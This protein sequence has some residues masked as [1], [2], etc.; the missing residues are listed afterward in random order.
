M[1]AGFLHFCTV[2][3][4]KE[5][6]W[7]WYDKASIVGNTIF[8]TITI[9]TN[10][11]LEEI[12]YLGSYTFGLVSGPLV[13]PAIL[14]K[15]IPVLAG[16]GIL[17]GKLRKSTSKLRTQLQYL[18][19]GTC[20]SAICIFATN[21][22]LPVA[23]MNFLGKFGP[24]CI[25]VFVLLTSYAI[26]KHRLMDVKALVLKSVAYT[27]LVGVIALTY[28]FIIFYIKRYWEGVI[29]PDIAFIVA[30]FVIAFGFQPLRRLIQQATDKVFAKGRYDF[31]EVISKLSNILSHS[32][33]ED[34]VTRP[35]LSTLTSELR[36]N[37]ACFVLTSSPQ[38]ARVETTSS[39][40]SLDKDRWNNL[41]SMIKDS[42]IMVAD[43][44]EEESDKKQVL[45]EQ[46]V[47][48]LVPLY[49]EE[50]N[51]GGFLALGEKKSGDA[52]T[53]EDIKLLEIVSPQI[54]ITLRNAE[55][56]RQLIEQVLEERER[57]E[58]DARDKIY[59]KLGALAKSAETALNEPDEMR[60]TLERL[61]PE[62]RQTVA[63]LQEIVL[64]EQ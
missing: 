44:L 31:G 34:D 2:F 9:S 20:I 18:F 37:N 56:Q 38:V 17:V 22:V 3:P 27:V 42:K 53:S 15:A 13:I 62:I 49:K 21:Q 19:L 51:L 61:E 4:K 41:S 6:R 40:C 8:F 12:R 23:G 57:I 52:Y 28:I 11:V 60:S 35:V 33:T 63:D 26:I 32:L 45:R 29:N 36:I 39:S 1:A 55:R 16:L 30:G 46:G 64:G 48:V 43:E 58:Q 47:E 59:N 10:L 7:P 5:S 54:S 24:F 50:D 14:V 25:I